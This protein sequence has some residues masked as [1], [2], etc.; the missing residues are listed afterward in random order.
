MMLQRLI[1]AT[2][3]FRNAIAHNDV[4]FDT[5]FRTG[6]IDKQVRNAISN[7]TGVKELT[8]GTITDY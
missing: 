4:I 3:D 6:N 5:R 2:K 1:F 7:A 8:F